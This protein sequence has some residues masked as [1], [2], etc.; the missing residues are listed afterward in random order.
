MRAL[1]EEILFYIFSFATNHYDSERHEPSVDIGNASPWSQDLRTK[2]ALVRVCKSWC[3]IASSFLY[4]RVYLH[5]IGQLVALVKV[6]EGTSQGDGEKS[7]YGH[8]VHHIHGRLYVPKHWENAYFKY[9]ARL[10]EICNT[11]Q[12]FAWAPVWQF[13]RKEPVYDR[14][15]TVKLMLL[16]V[17]SID[18]TLRSLRK[19]SFAVNTNIMPSSLIPEAEADPKLV[20]DN[21]EDLTCEALESAHLRGLFYVSSS[22]VMPSIKKLSIIAPPEEENNPTIEEY[23]CVFDVLE[24]HGAKLSTLVLDVRWVTEGLVKSIGDVL[25]LTPTLQELQI[26]TLVFE[27]L[28]PE[29]TFPGPFQNLQ[30]LV[31]QVTQ[32][33]IVPN[34][35]VLNPLRMDD[36]ENFLNMT[37][38]RLFPSLRTI[39]LLDQFFP[40]VP[41]DSLIPISSHQ[42]SRLYLTAWAQELQKRDITLVDVNGAK[43]VG[44]RRW[45]G[46]APNYETDYGESLVRKKAENDALAREEEEEEEEY[47]ECETESEDGVLDAA[48]D[49]NRSPFGSDDALDIL[50]D[51][52]N[53]N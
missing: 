19:L 51:T 10:L 22:F 35:S 6:L 5:R 3:R 45:T 30:K 42:E 50:G 52:N 26:S 44:R 53:S 36:L 15:S 47:F 7:S 2:K 25:K 39:G 13:P 38:G 33:C 17:P 4:D 24:T 18:S 32:D 11:A 16:S 14:S 43:L 34:N 21:L 49:W 48:S 12:T 20:F 28:P 23:P 46:K 29:S 37:T 8:L 27:A 1:P 41:L 40:S 31:L 9:T